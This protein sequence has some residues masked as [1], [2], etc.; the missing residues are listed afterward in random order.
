MRDSREALT[1]DPPVRR[2]Q[3]IA[4]IRRVGDARSF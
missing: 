3:R 2:R 1:I 4:A